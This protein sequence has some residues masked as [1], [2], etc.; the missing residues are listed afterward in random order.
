MAT[1]EVNLS[2][3]GEGAVLP[4]SIL[5]IA[6]Y[7]HA[8]SFSYGSRYES[9]YRQFEQHINKVFQ[10]TQKGSKKASKFSRVQKFQKGTIEARTDKK[11]R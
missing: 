6:F 7:S 8:S 4:T 5:E 2:S 11:M 9:S 10:D 1:S 3:L